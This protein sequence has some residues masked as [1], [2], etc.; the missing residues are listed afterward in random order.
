MPA[1]AVLACLAFAVSG[2]T[3]MGYEVLWT[4]ALEHFTHN[5][6]Y[7]YSAMLATFL[8]GLAVGSS[9]A[10]RVADRLSNPLL[11]LAGVQFGG[12]LVGGANHVLVLFPPVGI[13]LGHHVS[14]TRRVI[15]ASAT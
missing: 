7:A 3:A 5:S 2:F 13:R 11:A 8:L 10:A 15:R 9:L 12:R 4:R 6:T 14:I 1:L